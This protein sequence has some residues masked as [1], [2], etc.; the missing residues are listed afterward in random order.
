MSAR[1]S[2]GSSVL[3][4][5]ILVV[6]VGGVA[7][8]INTLAT[9]HGDLA[10]T[11]SQLAAAC[12]GGTANPGCLSPDNPDY[13]VEASCYDAKQAAAKAGQAQNTWKTESYDPKDNCVA[14]VLDSSL[15]NNANQTGPDPKNPN[16]YKCVGKTA[17]VTVDENGEVTVLS[18]T[19]I[20]VPAGKCAT[21][22]CTAVPD[23]NDQKCVPATLTSLNGKNISATILGSSS[24]AGSTGTDVGSTQTPQIS[25]KEYSDAINDAFGTPKL[26]TD[27]D[28]PSLNDQLADNNAKIDSINKQLEDCYASFESSC[29]T[30]EQQKAELQTKNVQ[31]TQQVSDEKKSDLVPSDYKGESPGAIDKALQQ[32]CPAGQYKVGTEC[33]ANSST[34]TTGP[35][36]GTT[37]QPKQTN[38]GLNGLMQSLFGGLM[39]ALTGATGGAGGTG[40]C[41]SDQNAY[42]QQLQQYQQQM[43]LY[44]QQLQQYNYQSYLAQQQ[45]YLPPPQPTPPQ[46]PCFN[47]SSSPVQCTTSPAQPDPAGCQGGTWRP[48]TQS[49]NSCISGWQCVPGNGS[50]TPVAQLSCQPQVADVGMSIAISFSCGNATGSA[51]QGFDT[52]NALSG[53]ASTTLANP[54]AGTNKAT[55]GLRCVNGNIPATASCSVDMARP[56]ITLV[57]I[58]KII[59]VNAS[60]TIGWVTT[61]MQSCTISSPQLPEFTSLNALSTT[62]NGGAVTPPLSESTEFLLHCT[63]LG[64]QTKDATTTVQV[65]APDGDLG[66][67]VAVSSSAEGHSVNRGETMTISWQSATTAPAAAEIDIWLY[68][69]ALEEPTALIKAYLDATGTYSWKLPLASDACDAN[70]SAVCG[71]DLVPGR[72]Y[73]IEAVLYPDSDP[74]SQYIDYGFTDDTF[75]VGS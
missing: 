39:K 11:G 66:G 67:G 55:F 38:S 32:N 60:S 56:S 5:L 57:T 3:A 73:A 72:E 45:G 2:R 68:D 6:L 4:A 63:T 75:T 15:K 14:A 48:T 28:L 24:N 47:Q 29:K 8:A 34:V 22:A 25:D 61:G 10:S 36:G 49:G 37:Q 69:T 18:G 33:K 54:L 1:F 52:G 46:Q 21:T 31:L 64:G 44:N 74:N 41:T 42:N 20:G 43:T 13:P 7:L 35:G 58:P 30:L 17:R 59:P 12:T 16:S 40:A 62:T 71:T 65:G 19:N 50:G 23:S 70:S 26:P 27:A 51:G 53:S 9:P